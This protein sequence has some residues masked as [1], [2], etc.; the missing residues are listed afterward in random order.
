MSTHIKQV[1]ARDYAPKDKHSTIFSTFKS[2]ESGEV[3]HLINDHDPIPLFY[4]FNAEYR[5][6]FT[7]E[8]LEN[9]PDIWRVAIGKK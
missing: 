7:W 9:G 6:L 4:Q 8:Y 5:D 3:M 2:L 1:D